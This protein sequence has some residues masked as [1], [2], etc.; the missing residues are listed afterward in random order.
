MGNVCADKKS[1]SLTNES[2][3]ITCISITNACK[4][5][6]YDHSVPKI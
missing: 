6:L 5:L 2:K 3:T 1:E 4:Y